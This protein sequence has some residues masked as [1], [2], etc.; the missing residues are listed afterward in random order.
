[1]NKD[2]L[3]FVFHLLILAVLVIIADRAVGRIE[4][5]L[6]A[7]KNTKL[8]Y[9]AYSQE[10]VDIV[11]LGSSRAS[12][13]YI[14][15]I[16]SD[17]T[18]LSCVNLG[19]D[20]QNIYYHFALLNL[21]LRHNTPEAVVYELLDIDFLLTGN[22]YSVERLDELAPVYGLNS[23][24]D[25]IIGLKGRTYWIATSVFDSY[26]YN[27][28]LFHVLTDPRQMNQGNGYIPIYGEWTGTREDVSGGPV[29][30]DLGK[31]EC[32]YSMIDLCR[33]RG[34]KMIVA[35]SPRYLNPHADRKEYAVIGEECD[36]RGARFIYFEKSQQD[37]AMFKDIM[38]L[39]DKGAR[40]YSSVMAHEIKQ[41]LQGK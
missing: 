29:E 21:H 6:F 18:K 5:V 26:R 14:P 24:V 17:T 10:P 4:N 35:V 3:R 23:T 2:F 36:R 8:T 12:H 20:G 34:I 11:I 37:K 13:H 30:F 9:A 19:V 39:N 1:M 40:W 25:S 16:I 28:K 38:H 15:A 22:K 32:L 27:S 7:R 41:Y 31:L 33:K